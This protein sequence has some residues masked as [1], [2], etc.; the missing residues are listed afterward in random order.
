MAGPMTSP[1]QDAPI[2][3]DP[4]NFLSSFFRTAKA[5]LFSPRSFYKRM[6]IQGG[7]QKPFLFLGCCAL[8]PGCCI[9]VLAATLGLLEQV[10]IPRVLAIL[11]VVIAFTFVIAGI[12]YVIITRLLKA[13]GTYEMAFRV[14]AYAAATALFCWIPIPIVVVFLKFYEAY[15]ITIGLSRAFSI[16]LLYL[17]VRC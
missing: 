15:L 3:F 16:T 8:F 7:L 5:V 2:D 11:T 10:Q 17:L 14:N 1:H 12:H 4:N 13:P 6:E 9:L